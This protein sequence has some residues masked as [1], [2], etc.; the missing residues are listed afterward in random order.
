[1]IQM[2]ARRIVMSTHVREERLD[3]MTYIAMNVGF[4]EVIM[5]HRMET[6]RECITDTGV[7]LV[8]GLE[9]DFLITA[10]VGTIDKV[11]A[12]YH[13]NGYERIPSPVYNKV[14][15]NAYH[16]KMQNIVKY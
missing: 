13:A 9:D 1:M 7:I 3:R 14:I 12:I 16:V 4:G 8:K 15:K 2:K 11:S 6:K 10:F 5:E